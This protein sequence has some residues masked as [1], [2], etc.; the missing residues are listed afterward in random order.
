MLS[1]GPQMSNAMISAPS[2]ANRTAWLR[3]WPRAAPLMNA[4]LPSTRPVIAVS[5]CP[6]RHRLP[7]SDRRRRAES[8]VRQVDFPLR[9]AFEDLFQRDSAFQAGQRGAQ[10][11]V[12]ADA[13][14]QV[15]TSRPVDV[16]FLAVRAELAIV[17]AGGPEEHHYYGA[18]GD[19]LTVEAD[20]AGHV[21]GRVRGRC[22]ESQEFLYGLRYQCGVVNQFA[23]LIRVF[24]ENLSGPTDQPGGGLV[25]RARDDVEIDQ[26]LVAGQSAG[27][28]GLVDELDVEQ[29][30]HDV[31]GRM[32]GAPID[33]GGKDFA[34]GQ[35][36]FV[37][38]GF[39]G[40]GA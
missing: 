13:E 2:W 16:E 20:V 34:G 32:G 9:E 24:G 36:A 30:G 38:H 7:P 39:A 26:Q 3:P 18:F 21:P 25:A 4:T 12:G 29:F 40:L 14:S 19:G 23:A 35:A 8:G 27:G 22:L 11:E 17:V 28:A 6:G 31:I 37:V 1:I 33:V 5:R 10:A 15:L